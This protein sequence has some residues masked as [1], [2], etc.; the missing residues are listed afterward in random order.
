MTD[1]IYRELTPNEVE[2]AREQKNKRTQSERVAYRLLPWCMRVHVERNPAIAFKDCDVA[3]FP[4]LFFRDERICIEIDGGYHFKRQRQDEYRDK[5][6]KSHGFIVIRIKN[7]D[8]RVDVAFWQR[9]L[10]G[11]NK[12]ENVAFHLQ[13]PEMKEELRRMISDEIRNWTHIGADPI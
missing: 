4:D 11:M 10:E 5:I 3:F 2:Q 6:F 1:N 8:T 7:L 13:L 12:V 9:L